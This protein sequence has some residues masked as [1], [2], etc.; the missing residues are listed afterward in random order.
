MEKTNRQLVY[1]FLLVNKSFQAELNA[2]G[3]DY[4]FKRH[5]QQNANWYRSFADRFNQMLGG[6]ISTEEEAISLLST[7]ELSI[8]Q[9][10]ELFA[11]RTEPMFKKLVGEAALSQKEE[12]ERV[13]GTTLSNTGMTF[14]T[15]TGAVISSK[16]VDVLHNELNANGDKLEELLSTG[17]ITQEQYDNFSQ[18]LDYIY[19]YFISQ[20]K[21]EQ[22]P[23]RKMTDS[24]YSQIEERANQ[25]GVD[26]YEQLRQE[27]QDLRYEHEQVQDMAHKGR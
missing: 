10:K 24:E 4:Y 25:N 14:A 21:G 15:E 16:R 11:L 8:E 3:T 26:F 27:T 22:I 2:Q 9:K 12:L 7:I 17:Q 6:N 20:S 5:H 1:E 23:F 19:G 18:S 13:L